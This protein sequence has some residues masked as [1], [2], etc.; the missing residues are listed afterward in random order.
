VFVGIGQ[1]YSIITN[2]GEKE[3]RLF[4]NF[5][6]ERVWETDYA[7]NADDIDKKGRRVSSAFLFAA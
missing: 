6:G 4:K 7:K 5:C 3:T 1:G 2:K